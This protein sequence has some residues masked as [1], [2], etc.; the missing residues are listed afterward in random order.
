MVQGFGLEVTV[1]PLTKIF[2]FI[3]VSKLSTDAASG[4]DLTVLAML[5]PLGGKNEQEG[6]G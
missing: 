3:L 4:F 1:F 6:T 2:F 5:K